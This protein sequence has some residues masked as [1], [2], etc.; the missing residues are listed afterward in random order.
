VH[1]VHVVSAPPLVGA[2]PMPVA[3]GLILASTIQAVHLTLPHAHGTHGRTNHQVSA[4]LTVGY[5]A[6]GRTAADREPASTP[7][8]LLI[9]PAVEGFPTPVA[10]GP[11]PVPITHVA[12]PI[13][14]VADL[15]AALVQTPVFQTLAAPTLTTVLCIAQSRPSRYSKTLPGRYQ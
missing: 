10:L 6:Q 8:L 7:S 3:L 15:P 1:P 2:M 12:P 11:T 14:P 9:M 13:A 4:S 5:M